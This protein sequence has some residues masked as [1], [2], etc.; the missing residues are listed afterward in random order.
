MKDVHMVSQYFRDI[1][2]YRYRYIFQKHFLLIQTII[3][4]LIF[5]G[6]NKT[7]HY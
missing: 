5:R 3:N 7:H 4:M 1:D 2:I 6:I